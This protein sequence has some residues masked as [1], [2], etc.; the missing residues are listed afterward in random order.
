MDDIDQRSIKMSRKLKAT[1]EL[2]W[3]VLTNP[4]HISAWWGPEGFTNTVYEMDVRPGGKWVFT[5]HGPDGVDY[6]NEFV[7]AIVEPFKKL[8][9]DHIKSPK[10]SI[11]ITIAKT[12]DGVMLD[13]SNVFDT[14]PTKEEAMRTLKADIGLEQNLDRLQKYLQHLGD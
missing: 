7:F 11:Y 8:V 4:D 1:P 2:V 13:W 6:E 10:F 3:A 12:E 14:I 9:M 5:M